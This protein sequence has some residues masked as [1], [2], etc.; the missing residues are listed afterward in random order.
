[1]SMW[2]IVFVILFFGFFEM[3]IVWG[4]HLFRKLKKLLNE[5]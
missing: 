3:F 5:D 4:W 1:M 2:E